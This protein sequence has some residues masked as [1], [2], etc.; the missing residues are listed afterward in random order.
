MSTP[1]DPQNRDN[2]LKKKVKEKN[3][4]L[5]PFLCNMLPLSLI[6]KYIINKY[7]NDIMYNTINKSCTSEILNTHI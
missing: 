1:N 6:K 2:F 5:D 3:K 7:Q 4:F